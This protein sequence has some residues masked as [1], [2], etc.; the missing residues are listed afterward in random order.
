MVGATGAGKTTF[1]GALQTA[2]LQDDRGWTI[3]SNDLAS[4]EEMI[5][6][7]TALTSKGEFPLPSTGI[8]AFD[9]TLASKRE[10]T[11]R[12]RRL[13]SGRSRRASRSPSS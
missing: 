7:N 3:G 11:E 6:M 8:D 5:K 13:R 9:W 12:T 1:L 4:R 2:L 10:R